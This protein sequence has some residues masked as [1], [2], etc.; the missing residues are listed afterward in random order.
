MRADGEDSDSWQVFLEK[1]Y[2]AGLTPEN[3]LRLLVADGAQGFRSAYEN[4]YWHTPLQRCVFHKLQ[5]LTQ[6]LEVPAEYDRQ[7]A[8]TFRTTFLRQAAEIWQAEEE[9]E[10]RHRYQGFCETWRAQQPEA[11]RKLCRDFEDTLTFYS[12]Q[13]QA[14]RQGELWPA[15]LLRTTS[16]LERMFRE[17]RR[18]Y[19]QAILFHS[20]AGLLALTAYLARRFS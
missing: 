15:R 16:P 13:E 6:A 14:A 9:A 12:I 5:N 18:R 2:Q 20:S 10:A 4:V 8:R 1:L 19:R 11:I 17:F 3:G 7:A